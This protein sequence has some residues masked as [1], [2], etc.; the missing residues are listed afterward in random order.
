MGPVGS[1]WLAVPSVESQNSGKAAGAQTR[2]GAHTSVGG[3]FSS[4]VPSSLD[5]EQ[6]DDEFELAFCAANR[7]GPGRPFLLDSNQAQTTRRG[8]IRRRSGRRAR[9]SPCDSDAAQR[10]NGR[11]VGPLSAYL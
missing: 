6:R 2:F 9:C 8:L 3:R 4:Q 5:D 10:P 1:K 11:Y 7:I